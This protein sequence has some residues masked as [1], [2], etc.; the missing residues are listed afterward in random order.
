MVR[1]FC[2]RACAVRVG[3]CTESVCVRPGETVRRCRVTG[4]RDA[5]Q[6]GLAAAQL[7]VRAPT[8]FLSTV[9]LPPPIV[10]RIGSNNNKVFILFHLSATPYETTVVTTLPAGH[11]P[12]AGPTLFQKF[13][14]DPARRA[15]FAISR[16]VPPNQ[17]AAPR[18]GQPVRGFF[19]ATVND[20]RGAVGDWRT[21]AFRELDDSIQNMSTCVVKYCVSVCTNIFRIVVYLYN[22]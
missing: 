21:C 8:S 5:S 7:D 22:N 18:D 16:R 1:C 17:G 9:R 13:D 6:V 2:A 10:F 3:G 19:Y 15:R 20:T 11:S 4:P 12:F 14:D